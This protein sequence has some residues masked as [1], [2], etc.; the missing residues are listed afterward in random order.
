[1]CLWNMDASAATNSIYGKISKSYILTPPH[2]QGY[3]MS[4]KCE[5]ALDELTVQVWLLYDHPNFK[6]WTLFISRTE[7]LTNGRMDDPNIRCLWRTFQA[8]GMKIVAACIAGET[9]LCVTTKN[10]WL[11]DRHQTKWSLCAALLRKRHTGQVCDANIN[12]VS[13]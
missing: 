4:L 10:V 13:L 11:Q 3:V 8:A 5:Q 12:K 1:M 7:L 2:S 9:K 6:Y